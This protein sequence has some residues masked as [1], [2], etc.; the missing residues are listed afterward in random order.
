MLEKIIEY[1]KAHPLMIMLIYFVGL[2]MY[3]LMTYI[4]Q[5]KQKREEER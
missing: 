2:C 4:F 5:R 1:F 3:A